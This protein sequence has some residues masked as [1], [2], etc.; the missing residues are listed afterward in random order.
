MLTLILLIGLVYWIGT[1][2]GDTAGVIATAAAVLLILVLF[3][4][5][6]GE[7][8]RAFANWVHYWSK[9]GDRRE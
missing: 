4:K 5:G 2:F 8:T 6:W 1:T 3:C 9:G 7:S